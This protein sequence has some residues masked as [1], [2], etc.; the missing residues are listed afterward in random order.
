MKGVVMLTK[1]ER[2]LLRH[3]NRELYSAENLINVVGY[4]FKTL[5]LSENDV[6]RLNVLIESLLDADIS[7]D[8][9]N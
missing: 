7:L 5:N 4:G 1:N 2:S 9:K 8:V 3:V 6:S